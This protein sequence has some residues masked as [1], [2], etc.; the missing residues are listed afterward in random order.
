MTDNARAR[1]RPDDSSSSDPQQCV[2][3]IQWGREVLQIES[4]SIAQLSDRLGTPFA[5]AC[6]RL[7]QGIETGRQV[8]VTGMGKAGLVGQK[9]AATL[10]STGTPAQFL[11]PSEAIHGDLG[12]VGQDDVVLAFS[13]S[14]ETDE[15]VRLLPS[16]RELGADVIAVTATAE[17]TLGRFASHTLAIGKLTEACSLGLAPSAT[18]AAMI[19]LGDALALVVSRARGFQPADFARYHPGGALGRRLARVDELMR[20]LEHCRVAADSASLREVLGAQNHRQRRTGATMLVD[21]QGRLSGIITDSDLVR[22]FASGEP[23]PLNQPVSK[24]MTSSPK[25]TPAGS[26]MS[27]ALETLMKYKISELPVV[28]AEGRPVGLIDVTDVVELLPDEPA[29]AVATMETAETAKTAETA[30]TV[31]EVKEPPQSLRVLPESRRS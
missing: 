18:T 22:R 4:A 28:D 2:Q 8:V 12:K 23:L 20:P 26:R 29:T 15:V 10:A 25:S 1:L 17:N 13:N 19:A 30:E 7:L 16:F 5:A 24:V 31:A 14:G 6:E 21:G 9:V 3:W 27:V 11:H